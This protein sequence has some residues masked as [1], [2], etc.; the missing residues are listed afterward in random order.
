ME[1]GPEDVNTEPKS[2][3]IEEGGQ[4]STM[5]G[6]NGDNLPLNFCRICHEETEQPVIKLGCQCR[7]E[8][9]GAHQTC[10]ERWF[11]GNAT[12]K[13]EICLQVASSVPAYFVMIPVEVSVSDLQQEMQDALA[14]APTGGERADT[15]SENKRRTLAMLIFWMLMFLAGLSA[16][17]AFI[18]EEGAT[19]PDVYQTEVT[20]IRAVAT[21]YRLEISVVLLGISFI[22][23][24]FL[25]CIT[26]T[27]LL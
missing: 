13:C 15:D 19:S 23:S 14:M 3:D 5:G 21:S 1:E 4:R 26:Y 22:S 9:A 8:L 16:V 12:N 18:L 24:L 27:H 20:I 11:G 7:G 17:T 2:S 25:D 10:M 6:I